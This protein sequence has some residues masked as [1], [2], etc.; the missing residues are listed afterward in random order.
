LVVVAQ[1]ARE[2]AQLLEHACLVHLELLDC[3]SNGVPPLVEE[4][5]R[6]LA[7]VA[8]LGQQLEERLRARA[9]LQRVRRPPH[10]S[11]ELPHERVHRGRLPRQLRFDLLDGSVQ[12]ASH[13]VFEAGE[14]GAAH[15][16]RRAPRLLL[17]RA[18]EG[19]RTGGARDGAASSALRARNSAG[20]VARNVQARMLIEGAGR[21]AAHLMREV[22]GGHQGSWELI[23]VRQAAHREQ[24]GRGALPN[25]LLAQQVLEAL[26][27][28]ARAAGGQ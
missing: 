7:D 1:H 25:G 10:P 27:L 11:I 13:R 6:V 18:R 22:I 15:G 23:E 12:R 19:A 4:L 16:M 2:G 26:R 20:A 28:D 3:F 9:E 21:Q 14:D 5:D 24:F 8:Q 17:G